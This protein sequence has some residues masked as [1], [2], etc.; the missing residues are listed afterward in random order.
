[1][2]VR[3]RYVCARLHYACMHACMLVYLVACIFYRGPRPDSPK[4][5]GLGCTELG[6]PLGHFTCSPRWAKEDLI[7][8]YSSKALRSHPREVGA[9]KTQE[10]PVEYVYVLERKLASSVQVLHG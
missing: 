6:T 2:Y 1:M 4:N 5:F 3:M 8:E 9:L 10:A 7:Y